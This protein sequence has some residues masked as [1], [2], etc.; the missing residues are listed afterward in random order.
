[1]INTEIGDED[2]VT[3]AVNETALGSFRILTEHQWQERCGQKQPAILSERHHV[4]RPVAAV[5]NDHQIPISVQSQACVH[6]RH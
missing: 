4:W 3:D 1:M 2:G 5:I 6:H